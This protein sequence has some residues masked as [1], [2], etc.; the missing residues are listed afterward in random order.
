MVVSLFAIAGGYGGGWGRGYGGGWG[1]G[2]LN[3]TIIFI[4]FATIDNQ[5]RFQATVDMV[6]VG[7]V[8]MV[9][10]GAADM[11]T[12]KHTAINRCSN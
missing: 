4:S 1:G 8:D 3:K 6:V 9:A 12:I 2:K 5:N 11:A 7:A 10:V